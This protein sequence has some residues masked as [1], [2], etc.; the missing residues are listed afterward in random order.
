MHIISTWT[1]LLVSKRICTLLSMAFML[2]SNWLCHP[3]MH[4]HD[5]GYSAPNLPCPS[6][7]NIL[8]Q[9]Y[10][11][12][13]IQWSILPNFHLPVDHKKWLFVGSSPSYVVYDLTTTVGYIQNVSRPQVLHQRSRLSWWRIICSSPN[14]KLYIYICLLTIDPSN[15]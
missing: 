6:W 3:N 4:I 9:G 14:V 7:Q 2:S 11:T 12:F 5:L 10:T 15:N 1:W 13:F 8:E